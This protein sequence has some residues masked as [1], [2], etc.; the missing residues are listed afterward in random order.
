MP[1]PLPVASGVAVL[2]FNDI[3]ANGRARERCT[4][5]DVLS[6]SKL[7][8]VAQIV[9]QC[10]HLGRPRV[11]GEPCEPRNGKGGDDSDEGC[12]H[13]HLDER[14]CP[15]RKRRFDNE[16]AAHTLVIGR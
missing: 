6:V 15:S 11:V 16:C 4:R 13:H 9:S 2:Q 7:C 5:R 14:E 8:G 12:N 10:D 1:M 3:P